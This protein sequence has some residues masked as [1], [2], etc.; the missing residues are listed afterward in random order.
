[1][2]GQSVDRRDFLGSLGISQPRFDFRG[3]LC[4][5][6]GD[7]GRLAGAVS[8]CGSSRILGPGAGA[9][10]SFRS[11]FAISLWILS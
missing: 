4:A 6:T 5:G 10:H 11:R 1:M 2:S 8:V 9:F 7:G 3:G